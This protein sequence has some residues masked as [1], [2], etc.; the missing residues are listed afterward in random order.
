MKD[1]NTIKAQLIDLD[2]R[3]RELSVLKLKIKKECEFFDAPLEISVLQEKIK[4]QITILEWVL[5]D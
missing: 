1:E 5:S 4:G 2:S 3:L